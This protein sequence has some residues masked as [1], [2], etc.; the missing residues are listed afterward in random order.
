M[1]KRL[2]LA[3]DLAGHSRQPAAEV[4]SNGVER[5]PRSVGAEL[6]AGH[7][8]EPEPVLE[9]ANDVFDFGVAA[10]VRLKFQEIAI[11]VGDEGEVAIGQSTQR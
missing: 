1:T 2:D 4:V 5:K 10:V 7:V 3:A 6:S 8:V 9:L 11:A